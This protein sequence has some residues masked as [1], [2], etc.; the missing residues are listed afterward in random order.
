M[1]F[2]SPYAGAVIASFLFIGAVVLS[3]CS[4]SRDP[5]KASYDP[6]RFNPSTQEYIEFCKSKGMVRVDSNYMYQA[7]VPG[8]YMNNDDLQKMRKKENK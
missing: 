3:A 1:N 4:P 2:N 5:E 8:I 6:T 7:C